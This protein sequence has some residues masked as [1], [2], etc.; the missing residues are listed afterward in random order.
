MFVHNLPHLCLLGDEDLR[1]EEEDD[2][3]HPCLSGQGCAPVLRIRV[4]HYLQCGRNRKE[5][6]IDKKGGG[7]G[8]ETQEVI[9]YRQEVRREKRRK[10]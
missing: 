9:R 10:R 7:G 8:G 6:E 1:G 5:E 2:V 4:S 3:E